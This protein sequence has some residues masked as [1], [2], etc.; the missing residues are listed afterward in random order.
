MDNII[1]PEDCKDCICGCDCTEPQCEIMINIKTIKKK[2][3]LN[4]V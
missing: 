3:N 4:S 2:I 1:I